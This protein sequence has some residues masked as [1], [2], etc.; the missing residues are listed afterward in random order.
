MSAKVIFLE[1]YH[2]G[3]VNMSRTKMA[4]SA[5]LT[6]NDNSSSTRN[7]ISKLHPQCN[8]SVS[9]SEIVNCIYDELKRYII[10]SSKHA[11]VATALWI[12]QTYGTQ[13]FS[14]SPVLLIESATPGCGKTTLLFFLKWLSP[15]CVL[16]SDATTAALARCIDQAHQEND[17][18][19]VFIDEADS[20]TNFADLTTLINSG[21]ERGIARLRTNMTDYSVD[22]QNL[23]APKAIARIAEGRR[24]A[25]ATLS[26]C[27]PVFLPRASA[28]ETVEELS[29][30][31]SPPELKR[32]SQQ[33]SEWSRANM[34]QLAAIRTD[35]P[36]HG[37]PADVW[38]SLFV[39]ADLAGGEWPE[40]VRDAALA[41]AP[42]E[43]PSE[44][45]CVLTA[46]RGVFGEQEWIST[47]K[48]VKALYD[49]EL[50]DNFGRSAAMWLADILRP[51]GIRA[52]QNNRAANHRG[53]YKADFTDAWA[54]Y[55]LHA[56]T[57]TEC[58]Q[59][60]DD[61]LYILLSDS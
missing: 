8:I 4:A 6:T 25:P 36:F 45:E 37:R 58:E 41:L 10:F 56:E 42:P 57:Q 29:R 9:L 39:V 1:K 7:I 24:L 18:L 59:D 20:A 40:R 14:H 30:V 2:K 19:R 28:G 47:H 15:R 61:S 46:L 21:F 49:M 44:F 26:R 54:L 16:T 50:C 23:F 52:K 51:L 48:I 3:D 38:R 27:I 60:A 33:L 31:S 34:D 53:Y 11:Y 5:E 17:V 22:V 12:V 43:G 32:L 55:C 13:A 35:L